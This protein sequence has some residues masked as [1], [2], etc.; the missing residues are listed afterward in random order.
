MVKGIDVMMAGPLVPSNDADL[1][2]RDPSPI[3]TPRRHL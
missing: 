2:I 3:A 1:T